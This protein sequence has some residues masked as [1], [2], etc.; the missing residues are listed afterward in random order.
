MLCAGE[1]AGSFQPHRPHEALFAL[2]LHLC[3]PSPCVVGIRLHHLFQPADGKVALENVEHDV[4]AA[5]LVRCPPLP[6]GFY[7][8][9]SRYVAIR[10]KA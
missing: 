3:R 7:A 10:S 8:A 4:L 2:A 9:F 6:W 5:G 1:A